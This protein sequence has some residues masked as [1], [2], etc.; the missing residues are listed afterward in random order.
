LENENP[1]TNLRTKERDGEIRRY[2]VRN[3]KKLIGEL[4]AEPQNSCEILYHEMLL[5]T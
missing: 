4:T 3:L 2:I 1:T 5:A